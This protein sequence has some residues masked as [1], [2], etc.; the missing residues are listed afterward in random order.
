WDYAV[1]LLIMS[2]V[3]VTYKAIDRLRR[4]GGSIVYLSSTSIAEANLDLALSTVLRTSLAGLLRVVA[5]EMGALG[6]RANMVLPGLARTDRMEALVRRT[7]ESRGL[8]VEEAERALT[9]RIPLGRAAD[10]SEVASVAVFLAS[11]AARYVNGAS[12]AVDGGL[13]LRV[14]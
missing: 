7:A 14:L 9:S 8:S 10:P 13:M 12:V 1:K 4:P 3:W 6:L 5:H 2:A 11:D